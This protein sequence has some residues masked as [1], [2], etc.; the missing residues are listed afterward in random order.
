M[1]RTCLVIGGVVVATTVLQQ[2][3]AASTTVVVWPGTV[4]TYR[5]LTGNAGFRGAVVAA[6]TAWNR[7]QLGVQ[8]EPVRGAADV[9]I[10]LAR[11]RCLRGKGGAAPVGFRAAG[12]RI[13]LSRSCPAVVRKLLVAHELGRALGLPVDDSRC[14]LMN[15][16]AVSDGLTYVVPWKCS[17]RHP[18][19]WIRSL[20]DPATARTARLMYTPPSPPGAI[21]LSVDAQGSPQITWTDPAQTMAA[22]TVVARG[23]TCPTD[24]DVLAGSAAV[25]VDET[26]VAGAHSYVDSGFAQAGGSQCYRAFEVNQFGRAAESPDAI[27][28]VSGGPIAGFAVSGSPVAGTSVA[29]TDTSQ[30]SVGHWTWNFGDPGSGAANV[31]DTTDPATGRT[32]S[33]DF[34]QPGTYEVTLTVTDT[35]GR[36]SSIVQEVVVGAAS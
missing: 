11:G 5:D 36:A 23:S 6:V 27:S 29:F 16:R 10:S 15:S 28:Y 20:I 31:L 1:L 19:A 13:V 12:S 9:T 14:S 8:L 33:H 34:A 2:A 30:G 3:T 18:P 4:I 21:S 24:R 32:P 22:T 17:R 25:V 26:Y 35:A 7:L